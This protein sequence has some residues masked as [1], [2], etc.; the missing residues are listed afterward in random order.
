M[1]SLYR[2]RARSLRAC[3]APPPTTGAAVSLPALP[4]PCAP[5]LPQYLSPNTSCT[6]ALVLRLPICCLLL[7]AG[8]PGSPLLGGL[9]NYPISP[10]CPSFLQ[11]YWLRPSYSLAPS[12]GPSAASVDPSPARP[13]GRSQPQSLNSGSPRAGRALCMAEE[14]GRRLSS[15]VSPLG[16]TRHGPGLCVPS[17]FGHRACG[18]LA[19]RSFGHGGSRSHCL[20]LE[21][22]WT[23]VAVLR[24]RSTPGGE[25]SIPG[26]ST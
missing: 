23:A 12:E 5:A 10:A 25:T 22:G 13:E 26:P 21:C 14:A 7:T 15:H 2:V 11:S 6:S 8:W 20:N 24:R 18:A 1:E 19:W 9:S 3:P 4:Q 16:P 17:A